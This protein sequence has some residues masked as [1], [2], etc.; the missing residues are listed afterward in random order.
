MI[1][2]AGSYLP[3]SHHKAAHRIC[4]FCFRE[5]G[6][7]CVNFRADRQYPV[8][9]SCSDGCDDALLALAIRGQ[10]FI[11][12]SIIREIHNKAV[13]AARPAVYEAITKIVSLPTS[14][15]AKVDTL[16]RVVM[17]QIMESMRQQSALT[18][19]GE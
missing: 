4:D 9:H 1:E 16:I 19:S 12:I 14:D 10:G 6:G 8:Y 17:A 13:V 15:W 2:K 3:N 5:C 11:P 7:Y 18:A